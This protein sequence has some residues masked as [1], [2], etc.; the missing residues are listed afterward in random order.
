[1]RPPDQ[2]WFQ[3]LR[4]G[5]F[6]YG[7]S[8]C[9]AAWTPKG[10][11][12]LIL[13][14]T[15]K[16]LA[17]RKLQ[18]YLPPVPE[19]YWEKKPSKVPAKIQRETKKA[20]AGKP[21]HYSGFDLSF[22]TPFQVGV[23]SATCQIPWGQFRTYGWVAQKA[24]S[25]RGFR[26]AGQALNRNTIPLFIPCHRVIAGGNRLGGYGGGLDWKIK[27]LKNEGVVVNQGIV[28]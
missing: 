16:A 7:E 21:F 11:S 2:K 1:M 27:L 10:L 25:P 12:A 26:A 5:L 3:S 4:W 20:L 17:L 9:A 22:L 24:G 15:N 19:N 8:W 28:R 18:E 14:R 6:A 23:L 13:P